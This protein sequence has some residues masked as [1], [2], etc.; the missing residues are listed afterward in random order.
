MQVVPN[1]A[2]IVRLVGA[3]F[4]E[5]NDEWALC[6][7]YMSLVTLARLGDTAEVRPTAIPATSRIRAGGAR[8]MTALLH[9]DLG[10]D[11]GPLR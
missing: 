9:H 3:L 4:L 8:I 11:R 2:A 6:R 10:H 7:R 1:E 5:Q